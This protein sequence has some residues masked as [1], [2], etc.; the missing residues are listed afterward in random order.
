MQSINERESENKLLNAAFGYARRGWLVMP[1]HIP[2]NGKC[3]CEDPDCDSIGKHPLTAHGLKDATT[4]ETII[5]RWWTEAPT[6]NVGIRTGKESGF[7][8]VGPDGQSGID[9][10]AELERQHGPLPKT[11][12][13]RS[14]GGGQHYYFRW[15]ADGKIKNARNHN[16]LPIDV[17]GAGGYVV[18]PPSLHTSGNA[19]TW[20]VLPDEAPL[21]DAPDWLLDWLRK[22]KETGTRKDADATPTPTPTVR[23]GN[24]KLILTVKAEGSADVRERAIAYLASCPPAVSKQ[25]GHNQTFDVARAIVYGFDLGPDTGFDLLQ[26]HYNQ[27]CQPP[28]SEVELRHKCADADEKPFD[29]P[30]GYLLNGPAADGQQSSATPSATII[31][32]EG[33]DI[34]ALPMPE[35]APWPQL[36]AEALHGLAGEI[37]RT[38]APETESAPV[39]ILGQLLV[40]AG[41]AVGRGPH[42]LVES[43]A[44]HGNLFCCLVGESSRGRKGTSK[45]RVMQ[46]MRFADENWCDKCLASGLSS[47]E[48]LIWAVRDPIEK[49]EPVKERGRVTGYQ[50]VITD[51]GV[52]DKRLLADESEFAQVLRVLQREGNSLSPVIR[53]SWDTGNLRTLTKNNPARATNAHV[54]ISAHITRPELL[55]CLKDTEVLNGFGN[56]FLWLLVRRS[57]LLPFGGQSLDLSVLGARL[58]YAIASARNVG[59]M[60]RTPAASKLWAEAYPRLTADRPGLYGAVTGRAEAQTLRLSMM[61]ALLDA[62]ASIDAHHLLAALA[63]W[64]Y[65]D[66]SARLIF[67]AEPAD[68]L[69]GL[70]LA[71]LREAPAGLTRT[72]IHDAFGRNIPAAKLLAALAWLRDRG[73]AR[74]EKVQT[75]GRPAERWHALRTNEESPPAPGPATLTSFVRNPSHGD[76]AAEEVVT[77]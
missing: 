50:T 71:K 9:A 47:G 68:P 19:Y 52:D 64:E 2:I 29:K 55:K 43:D 30:R 5:R 54:S 31:A 38:L 27:R 62:S 21:A 46:M 26:A 14:G 16:G 33:E 76:S 42:F 70:V 49:T 32:A 73:Q 35:P 39:A 25:G 67:G 58:N 15:P 17:R 41:N 59:P 12:R 77:I 65:A 13:L 20:E 75:G 74:A 60:R 57:Q 4:D 56:R 1:L 23:A 7:F 8:M 18:A 40:A 72:E 11:P 44:H 66:A 69:P 22:P 3:S 10:L 53:Q 24:G 6:A 37:V 34:E 63:L 28:W 45:G 36:R 61:Y 51:A 48:G